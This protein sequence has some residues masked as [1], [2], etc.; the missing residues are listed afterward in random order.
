MR[1][2]AG[3]LPA[4]AAHKNSACSIICCRFIG[5]FSE[6]ILFIQMS[7]PSTQQLLLS[8]MSVLQPIE[9]GCVGGIVILCSH[10]GKSMHL[11]GYLNVTGEEGKAVLPKALTTANREI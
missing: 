8:G 10:T 6:K 4:A 11:K 5:S 9:A 1:K 3:W 2:C 7:R